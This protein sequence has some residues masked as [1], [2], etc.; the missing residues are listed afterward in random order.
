VIGAGDWATAHVH[1][2]PFQP[3]LAQLVDTMSVLTETGCQAQTG[4]PAHM[5]VCPRGPWNTRLLVETVLSMRT[6][7]CPS[8]PMGHR[9]WA[10]CRARV[11]WTMAVF[12]LLARWGM[13]IDEH[14]MIRLSIAEFS[15]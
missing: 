3:L 5:Q 9:G 14:D 13:E 1:A 4:D 6:T 2:S 8:K 15:L 12:Y 7:G 11:A 10:S